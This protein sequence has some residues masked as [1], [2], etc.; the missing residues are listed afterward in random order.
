MKDFFPGY[1]LPTNDEMD[2]QWENGL[3][4]FDT[5]VLLNIYAYPEQARE[6]F[7]S[8]L[9][10][11]KDMTWIPYQ[12]MLEFHRNRY[13]RITTSN[14]SVIDL[15]DLIKKSLLSVED[16][17]KA[18]QFDKRNTGIV[19]IDDRISNLKLAGNSVLEAIETACKRLSG[20]NLDDA[21]AHRLSNIYS[22]RIGDAPK[23]Q[24]ELDSLVEGGEHRYEQKIPPGFADAKDKNA[25]YYHRGLKYDARYGDLIVWRQMINHVREVKGT[26]VVFV[27]AEIKVDFWLKDDRG[28]IIGPLPALIEE[29]LMETGAT[30]FW[31]YSPEQ[32]LEQAKNRDNKLVSTNTINEVREV[33]QAREVDLEDESLAPIVD[34]WMG[35]IQ[36]EKIKHYLM[37]KYFAARFPNASVRRVDDAFLLGHGEYE[38]CFRTF[39]LIDDNF[40]HIF[41]I[42]SD[43]AEPLL[44]ENFVVLIFVPYRNWR[45]YSVL[46]IASIDAILRELMK[47]N[48]ISQITVIP[49]DGR[50]VMDFHDVYDDI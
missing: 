23:D 4:I 49:H 46:R 25:T 40:Q 10:S 6:E 16:G 13:K 21:V 38:A 5:N 28:N 2:K 50:S 24:G 8:A 18:I 9:E 47:K 7:I 33:T 35:G 45:E 42:C 26:H 11:F 20:A 39:I 43:L 44:Y 48:S 32:F 34:Q 41:K 15:R 3:F 17:F 31:L 19:D 1:Y 14:K 22:S 36:Q 12:V 30:S 37:F 29:F 27:T